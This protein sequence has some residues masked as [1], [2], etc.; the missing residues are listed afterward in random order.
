MSQPAAGTKITTRHYQALCG[1]ALTAI[2][3]LQIQD[4]GPEPMHIV[5]FVV[6]AAGIALRSRLLSPP[7]VLIILATTHLLD[8]HQSN[9]LFN[10][11]FRSVRFLAPNDVFL[12]MAVLTYVIAHYRLF[13]LR[14]GVLPGKERPRSE[15]SLNAVELAA[16]I[17][18]VPLSV[19]A[20]ELA[21]LLLKL[22]WELLGL[23]QRWKQL[24]VLMWV[25]IVVM[26]VAGH[27]FRFWRRLQMTRPLALLA[28]QDILW[29]ET[30][31]DQRRI[32]RWIVWRRQK[33]P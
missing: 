4:N 20:A 1:L 8:Q 25:V 17:F 29:N 30:R 26:F 12:C 6:G 7:L 21:A 2:F 23:P 27:L 3:L 16:L 33:G 31:D 28:L 15:E 11:D 24:V 9:Q 5:L 32:A 14:F 13:T 19:L 18:P 22:Q 10:P